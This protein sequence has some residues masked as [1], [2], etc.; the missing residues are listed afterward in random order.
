MGHRSARYSCVA[1][2]Y[3][4]LLGQFVQVSL[5]CAFE[6]MHATSEI[7]KGRL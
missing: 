4:R 5:F 7:N 2:I 3:T 1:F 6:L